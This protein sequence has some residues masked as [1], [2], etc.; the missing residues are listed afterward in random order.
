MHSHVIVIRLY[1]TKQLSTKMT[2]TYQGTKVGT[3]SILFS[4]RLFCN[5]NGN[6]GKTSNK[7]WLVQGSALITN[8]VCLFVRPCSWVK[9]QMGGWV[10]VLNDLS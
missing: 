2:P 8:N 4:I 9:P 1:Q 6:C 5:E 7:G 10:D 3:L